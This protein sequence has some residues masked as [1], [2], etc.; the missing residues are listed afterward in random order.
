MRGEN[1]FNVTQLEVR[2]NEN[3]QQQTLCGKQAKPSQLQRACGR[4]E[5]FQLIKTSAI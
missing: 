4:T 1:Q 5:P 2:N 3:A